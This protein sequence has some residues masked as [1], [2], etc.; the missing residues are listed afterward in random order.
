MN[1]G[2]IPKDAKG[3]PRR[4]LKGTWALELKKLSDRTP[5]KYKGRYC[6][7]GD[8]QTE[9]VDYFE[10]YAPVVQC[11]TVRG[12][13]IILILNRWHTEQVDYIYTVAQAEIQEGVYVYPPP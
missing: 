2:D 3:K 4:I 10:I 6:V 1:R 5:S 11:S 12:V 13:L 8:L 9:R 7:R